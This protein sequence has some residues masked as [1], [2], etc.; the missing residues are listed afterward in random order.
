MLNHHEQRRG[1]REP[2]FQAVGEQRE[3][4]ADVAHHRGVR[5]AQFLAAQ[6]HAILANQGRCA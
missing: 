6:A 5:E 2:T 4:G 3:A 1:V